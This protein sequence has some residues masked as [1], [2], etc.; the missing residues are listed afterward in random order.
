MGAN[1]SINGRLLAQTAV[2][3]IKSTVVA[4]ADNAPTS[5]VTTM[6]QLQ[7]ALDAGIKDITI[8]SSIPTGMSTVIIPS[9]TVLRDYFKI[10]FGNK[11]VVKEGG[12]LRVG[13]WNGKQSNSR[14]CKQ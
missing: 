11:I 8:A 12:N 14:K 13:N 5:S 6:E 4:P 9:G 1:A 3:L 2:T 7:M 10:G